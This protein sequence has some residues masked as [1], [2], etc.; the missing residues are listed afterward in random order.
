MLGSATQ[1][2]PLPSPPPGDQNLIGK[3]HFCP[4]LQHLGVSEPC[5]LCKWVFLWGSGWRTHGRHRGWCHALAMASAEG[6]AGRL[7][8]FGTCADVSRFLSP[9]RPVPS[10]RSA[11]ALCPRGSHLWLSGGASRVCVVLGVERVGRNC[12]EKYVRATGAS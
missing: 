8:E 9:G 6:S 3:H 1:L 12:S 11:W 2:L 7:G 5:D 10:H 4:S